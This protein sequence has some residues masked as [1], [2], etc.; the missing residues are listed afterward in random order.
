MI[1]LCKLYLNYLRQFEHVITDL[2]NLYLLSQ[3]LP[4]DNYRLSNFECQILNID[5]TLSKETCVNIVNQQNQAFE[6]VYLQMT[7]PI[8]HWINFIFLYKNTI[9]VFDFEI[10]KRAKQEKK[11]M[12]SKT[13]MFTKF[14]GYEN[15]YINNR[16]F[17]KDHVLLNIMLIPEVSS[18]QK[19]DPLFSAVDLPNTIYIG[20][21]VT[22]KHAHNILFPFWVLETTQV[23]VQS[24]VLHR[25]LGMLNYNSKKPLFFD[26]LF[27]KPKPHRRHFYQLMKENNLLRYCFTT[28]HEWPS[29]FYDDTWSN[30]HN[31]FSIPAKFIESVKKDNPEF[32]FR[33]DII[34]SNR[35]IVDNMSDSTKK[36]TLGNVYLSMSQFIDLDCY[37]ATA[38][39]VVFETHVH[40]NLSLKYAT[41]FMTEK[42]A[43]PILAKRMFL[44]HGVTNYLE[45]LRNLGFQTF[46]GIIDETYDK[47]FNIET[48]QGLLIKEMKKLTSVD[49]NVILKKIEPIV[50]HNF[51]H[52]IKLYMNEDL[53]FYLKQFL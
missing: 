25:Q 31:S 29:E 34:N 39:S 32:I 20:Q 53:N 47:V 27:G 10:F 51:N 3:K 22:F 49:Q 7:I 44:V 42:I 52:M 5:P 13:W 26:C 14:E 50:Q 35:V 1:N 11:I 12:V 46:H 18:F 9:F 2:N 19:I 6:V 4:E 28:L 41:Y 30:N 40:D 21:A 37:N 23:N 38:Y 45:Q 8:G 17:V 15:V 43:K 33:K 16:D 24:W 48:R 36:F